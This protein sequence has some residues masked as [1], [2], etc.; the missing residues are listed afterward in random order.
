MKWDNWESPIQV[1]QKQMQLQQEEQIMKAIQE[2]GVVVDK[3]E[4]IRCMQYDRGQYS[5]GYEQGKADAIKE[6]M[7]MMHEHEI[8]DCDN[9]PFEEKCNDDC[10]YVIF[11]ELKKQKHIGG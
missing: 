1:I 4:L 11:R 7:T 3:E 2:V 5:K 6:V 8:V 10:W 9:C